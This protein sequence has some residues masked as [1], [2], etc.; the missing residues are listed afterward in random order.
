MNLYRRTYNKWN[1]N[2]VIRLQREY[3][4]LELS[5]QEIAEK[6]QRSER[7]ILCKLDKEGI[8]EN[9]TEARGFCEYGILQPDLYEYVMR[10]QN[11]S[12]VNDGENEETLQ[13]SPTEKI[14]THCYQVTQTVNNNVFVTFLLNVKNFLTLFFYFFIKTMKDNL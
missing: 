1:V 5:I 12:S 13:E 4:L 3:E 14:H 8:I 2:E 7:A 6:H 9:W 10:L 11:R